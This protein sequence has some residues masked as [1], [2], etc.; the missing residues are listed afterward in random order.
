LIV[1]ADI[2]SPR[3]VFAR[4]TNVGSDD[5]RTQ[6][7]ATISWLPITLPSYSLRQSG[8]GYALMSP[9]P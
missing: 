2:G 9:R 8:S 4:L 7:R 5:N 1:G 3:C 6:Q